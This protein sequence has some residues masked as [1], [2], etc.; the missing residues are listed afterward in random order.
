MGDGPRIDWSSMP[1]MWEVPSD[2]QPCTRVATGGIAEDGSLLGAY[3]AEH[4][5][6]WRRELERREERDRP[7]L[8][9]MQDWWRR[10]NAAR[11]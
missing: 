11:G 7:K 4:L 9:G 3:C 5:A 6:I 1:C 10:M 8:P 2:E